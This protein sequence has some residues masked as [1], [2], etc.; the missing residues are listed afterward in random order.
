MNALINPFVV[1][2]A[3]GA[4]W[5]LVWSWQAAVLLACVWAG[6]KIFRVK[7]PALRHQVWLF[8]LIAVAAMPILSGFVQSL[9]LPQPNNRAL[10]YA[11]ELPRIVITNEA[12]P[13]FQN[14][15]PAASV[16][17][18][19]TKPIILSLSFAVWLWGVCAILMKAAIN[20]LRLHRLRTGAR[21]ASLSD[22]DCDE[23]DCE[24]LRIGR[25]SIALSDD[26]RSPILLGVLRPTIVFPADITS[27]TSLMERNAMLRH[28]LAHVER[29]DHFVNLFQTVLGAVFFFHPLA[30]YACRQLTLEREMACDDHVVNSGAEAENYAESIIKAAERSIGAPR[31]AHQ[32]AL[33]GTRQILERRIEMILNKDRLRV[34]GH[35]WRYLVLSAAMIAIVS[36]ALI[37]SR[38]GKIAAQPE[39]NDKQILIDMVREV[40]EN[41]P[42]RVNFGK[43]SPNPNLKVEHFIGATGEPMWRI[44][45]GF[46]PRKLTVTRAVAN[47]FEVEINGDKA[48]VEFN[49]LISF[50]GPDSIERKGISD[51]YTVAM[52]KVNG[53]WRGLQPP[54]PPPPPKPDRVEDVDLPPPPPPP[55]ARLMT[56]EAGHE[57]KRIV[58]SREESIFDLL[59]EVADAGIRRDTDFYERVLDEGYKQTGPTGEILNKAQAIAEVKRMDYTIKK[60]EF[61]DLSVSGNEHSAF[62]TFLATVYFDANGQDSTAQFRYTV[63]FIKRGGQLKIAAAHITQKN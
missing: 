35:Q 60:L 47:D 56:V 55:P 39:N 31:G 46:A 48:T 51:R 26:I 29:R 43:S 12:A 62:A 15:S 59:R 1:A 28:E 13:V 24:A 61:D 50:K 34:F 19:I 6:L 27:W 52:E 21:R 3:K 23:C 4:A 36:V 53:Q 40:V 63:N 32:L 44:L 37:S 2:S 17:P 22:F 11:V 58:H 45:D 38:A 41:I 18:S 14:P 25:V 5:L 9:P 10:T 30:R 33:F 8:A 42:H 49:G 16:K 20:G 7:S 54:P 57:L